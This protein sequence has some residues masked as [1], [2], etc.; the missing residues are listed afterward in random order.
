MIRLAAI[1]MMKIIR[2]CL[3]WNWQNWN[4]AWPKAGSEEDV[5]VRKKSGVFVFLR[6]AVVG[7]LRRRLV[8]IFH[9]F[10]VGTQYL[11]FPIL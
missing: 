5:D 2:P 7:G 8:F 4:R 11:A 6:V 10:F 3:A 1:S 9:K